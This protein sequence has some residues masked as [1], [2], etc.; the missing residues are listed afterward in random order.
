MAYRKSTRSRSRAPSRS[1]TARSSA[2]RTRS[3]RSGNRRA[4]S[5]SA[6]RSAVSRTNKIVVQ[7]VGVPQEAQ[8]AARPPVAGL[9]Q[10]VSRPPRNRRF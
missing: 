7:V 8:G 9:T 2:G 1:R 10:S 4:G 6:R 3:S 5:V